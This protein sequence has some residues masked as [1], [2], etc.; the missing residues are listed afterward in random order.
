M[1]RDFEGTNIGKLNRKKIKTS[2]ENIIDNANTTFSYY[3]TKKVNHI[4]F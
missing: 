2:R 4:N 1:L 3:S